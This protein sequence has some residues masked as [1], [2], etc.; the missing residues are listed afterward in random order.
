MSSRSMEAGSS[1]LPWT[2]GPVNHVRADSIHQAP[3]KPRTTTTAE[4]LR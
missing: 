4:T 1:A 3:A 2:L